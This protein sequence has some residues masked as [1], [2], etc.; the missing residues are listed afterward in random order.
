MWQGNLKRR[1]MSES[2]GYLVAFNNDK[3][4]CTFD[5]DCTEYNENGNRFIC[6]KGFVNPNNGVISFDNSLIGM[7]TVF[8]IVTL[9]GWT[10]VFTYVSKT[11]KDKIYVNPII[12]FAYFHFFVFV[13]GFYLI[14]LF[15][16]VTNSEFEKIEILKKELSEKKSFVKLIK[17]KYDLKEKEKQEKK[18]KR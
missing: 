7:V 5:S 1:C 3:G 6:V 16:A 18:K 8:V 12:I 2:Y 4:M 14:N 9:E 11:F 17:S 13:G 15:L 10:Q